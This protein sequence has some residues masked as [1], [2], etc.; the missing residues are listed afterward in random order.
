MFTKE[1]TELTNYANQK[2]I[3]KFS[4]IDKIQPNPYFIG[5]GNPNSEILFVGQ[6]MAIDPIKSPVTLEMESFR[7]PEH[8][9]KIINEEILDLNYSFN[10]KNGFQNPRKPYNEKAKGTWRSYKQIVETITNL[11]LDEKLGFFEHCFITEMNT[12]TSKSQLGFRDCK[13]RENMLQKKFFKN[14]PI[15]ILAT[16]SY[17]SKERIQKTFDVKYSKT[18]SDSQPNKRLEVY[19]DGVNNRVLINTRQLSNFRFTREERDSYFKKIA[20]S[21][22]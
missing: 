3:E 16:G 15:T 1:F 12:S 10:G 11:K 5:F 18:K 14:F 9:T 6:E 19:L 22:K 17:I 4:K 20:L 8:W 2:S 7:N 21:A 13:E